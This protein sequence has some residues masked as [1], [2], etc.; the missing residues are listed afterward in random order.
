MCRLI[1]K[2][3]TVVLLYACP[4]QHDSPATLIKGWG[5]FCTLL[6]TMQLTLVDRIQSDSA[7]VLSLGFKRASALPPPPHPLSPSL[8]HSRRPS[9]PLSL[10]WASSLHGTCW[11]SSHHGTYGS[12]CIIWQLVSPPVYLVGREQGLCLQHEKGACSPS[13]CFGYHKGPIAL[14]H[15]RC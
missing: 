3:A 5:L 7:P 6:A 15:W 8:S 14:G 10:C 12:T 13:S 2:T 9:L 11:A 4:W 1:A